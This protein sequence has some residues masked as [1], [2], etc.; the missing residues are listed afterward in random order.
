MEIRP[1]QR[2]AAEA[3]AMGASYTQAAAAA[4][5]SRMTVYRWRKDPDFI[6][7]YQRE[8]SKR[9]KQMRGMRLR[10][11]AVSLRRLNE[12]LLDEK[13]EPSIVVQIAKMFLPNALDIDSTPKGDL[14]DADRRLMESYADMAKD[15][16]N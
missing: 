9:M 2:I 8:E 10:L 13:T 11:T 16:A 7:Q 1:K 12:L 6:A 3:L 4:K 5:V 15:L 14:A